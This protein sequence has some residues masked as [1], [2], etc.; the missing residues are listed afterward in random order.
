MAAFPA[1]RRLRRVF[2]DSSSYAAL[3]DQRDASHPA[4][5][6]ILDNIALARYQPYTTNIILI[7]AHALILSEL[8][9]R[10]ASQFLKDIRRGNT[11]IMRV[12]ASDEEGAQEILFRYSDKQWSLADATSF[13]V[14]ERLGIR[15]ALALDSDFSQYGFIALTP[16]TVL[17]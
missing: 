16:E 7:E 5:R 14:M 2:Q 9:N 11:R 8:G 13:A 1:S 6:L 3:L 15:Y 4:A 17:P 12:R 10:I